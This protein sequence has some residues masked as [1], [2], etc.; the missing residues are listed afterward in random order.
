[1]QT[2]VELLT[3]FSMNALIISGGFW[4]I[5]RVAEKVFD[6]ILKVQQCK[7]NKEASE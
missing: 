1:M 5:L 4:A 7:K 2:F 3:A 6:V